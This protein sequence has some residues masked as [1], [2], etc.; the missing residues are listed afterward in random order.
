MKTFYRALGFI[1]CAAIVA[2][3]IVGQFAMVIA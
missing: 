2:P 1:G 3:F